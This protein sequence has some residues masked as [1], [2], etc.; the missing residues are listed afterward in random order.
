[1]SRLLDDLVHLSGLSP[2][3]ART[4]V[5]RAIVRA[6]IDPESI[7]RRDVERVLP[8]LRRALTVYLGDMGADDRA[9]RIRRV[10]NE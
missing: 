10:I 7:Q 9:A 5:R 4:V 2:I 6:G 8:E 3:F 1:M